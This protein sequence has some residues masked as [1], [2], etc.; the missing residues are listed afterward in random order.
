MSC[1]C[2]DCGKQYKVDLIIPNELW[3]QIKPKEKLPGSGLLCGACIMD[4]IEKMSSY[5][6]WYL[7]KI[8]SSNRSK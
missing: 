8:S 6:Y 2:Q 5:D 7:E 4:R 1:R 3:Q